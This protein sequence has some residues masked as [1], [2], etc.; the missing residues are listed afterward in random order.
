MESSNVDFS[1]L[2]SE[3]RPMACVLVFWF[4][5][6]LASPPLEEAPLSPFRPHALK[7]NAVNNGIRICDLRLVFAML[8]LLSVNFDFCR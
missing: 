2:G 1:L 5:V 8:I 7:S 4:A 6:V 3:V